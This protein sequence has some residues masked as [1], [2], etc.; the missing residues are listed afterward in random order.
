MS[1]VKYVLVDNDLSN[2]ILCTD[3]KTV[4][5]YVGISRQAI[6]KYMNK[7]DYPVKIRQFT[8][9]VGVDVVKSGKNPY[10]YKS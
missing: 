9:F 5:E 1:K 8:L 4:A 2:V 6:Y 3:I 7:G 10:Q